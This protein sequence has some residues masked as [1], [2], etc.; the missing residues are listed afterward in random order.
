MSEYFLRFDKQEIWEE[1]RREIERIFETSP[2]LSL[3]EFEKIIEGFG[4]EYDYLEYRKRRI[5]NDS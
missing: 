1:E 2:L 5:N 3:E 4:R